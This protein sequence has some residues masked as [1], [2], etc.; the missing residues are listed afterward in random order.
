MY[1]RQTEVDIETFSTVSEQNTVFWLDGLYLYQSYTIVTRWLPWLAPRKTKIKPYYVEFINY[2]KIT[3]DQSTKNCT[4]QDFQ[5]SLFSS[6]IWVSPKE[7]ACVKNEQ[8]QK[9]TRKKI[10]P[11]N[12]AKTTILSRPILYQYKR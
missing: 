9:T 8:N 5:C 11:W 1:L 3:E 2:T 10:S 7:P 12:L 6:I 4:P